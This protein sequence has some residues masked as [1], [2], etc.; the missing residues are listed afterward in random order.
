[1]ISTVKDSDPVG[2]L[3]TVSFIVPPAILG[4]EAEIAEIDAALRSEAGRHLTRLADGRVYQIQVLPV[5][6]RKIEFIAHANTGVVTERLLTVLVCLANY[7]DCAIGEYARKEV[8]SGW[9]IDSSGVILCSGATGGFKFVPRVL[10][11]IQM[12]QRVE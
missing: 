11:G 2:Q 8:F 12:Y 6:E 1:M 4:N 3:F 5:R 7:Q 9:Q 10:Y